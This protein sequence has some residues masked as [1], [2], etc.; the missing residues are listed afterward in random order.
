MFFFMFRLVLKSDK[1]VVQKIVGECLRGLKEDFVAKHENLVD[2]R[3]LH[4]YRPE[5]F[6]ASSFP[7]QLLYKQREN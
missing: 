4:K 5:L 3:A 2:A 7:K 6:T 1:N